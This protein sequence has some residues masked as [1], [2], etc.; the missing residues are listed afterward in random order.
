MKYNKEHCN[1]PGCNHNIY[2][3][4]MC[5]EHY[6]FY[7]TDDKCREIS[8]NVIAVYE[9]KGS[10]KQM[11]LAFRDNVIHHAFDHPMIRYEHFPLEHVFLLALRCFDKHDKE[12]CS[13]VI[14][15]FDIPA[16]ENIAMLKR[17]V[18]V[19]NVDDVKIKPVEFYLLS[20]QELISVVPFLIFIFCVLLSYLLL[21]LAQPWTGEFFGMT[22]Q[23]TVCLYK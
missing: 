20:K 17:I 19:Q 18:N 2:R 16:N 8:D 9:G 12:R 3:N 21:H 6:D 15:D 23:E 14:E 13:R 5:K 7:L 22:Y 1:I 4:Y 10:W 11:V